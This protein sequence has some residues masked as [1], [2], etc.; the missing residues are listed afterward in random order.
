MTI[1][2]DIISYLESVG[3]PQARL[4]IIGAL[5]GSRNPASVDTELSKMSRNGVLLRNAARA[6]MLPGDNGATDETKNDE[7]PFLQILSYLKENGPRTKAQL[8]R[9]LP[10]I[11][12]FDRVIED[13]VKLQY[14]HGPENGTLAAGRNPKAPPLEEKPEN[15]WNAGFPPKDKP[16]NTPSEEETRSADGSATSEEPEAVAT[17]TRA[18]DAPDVS[19][20]KESP[21][22]VIRP[23]PA[24]GQSIFNAVPRLGR[25]TIA[26][27]AQPAE[28]ETAGYLYF[29]YIVGETTFEISGRGPK[30]LGAIRAA[31]AQVCPEL[32]HE[33][34][35]DDGRRSA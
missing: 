5:R 12:Q 35:D 23:A 29:R 14:I 31:L 27:G 7:A 4:E 21:A 17:P 11:K 20:A 10:K 26:P 22:P 33:W 34:P 32:A 1:Q 2:D 24:F 15:R 25:D 6:Y 18:G 30:T 13:M 19:A 9:V 28:N 16:Q 8:R 3:R